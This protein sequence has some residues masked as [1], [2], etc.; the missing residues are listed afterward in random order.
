[1]ISDVR[2]VSHPDAVR[3]FDTEELREHF[4]VEGLFEPG[5]V[6]LT[7]S[8]VE[9]FVIGG[10]TPT[11]QPLT[12]E[13]DKATIGSPNFLD[14][15]ELG[16]FNIGGPGKV[17][18]DGVSYVLGHRDA[19]YVAQGTKSVVF[20]S[21]DAANPARFYLLSTPAHARYET[22]VV[23]IAE[24]KAMVLGDQATANRRT[25]YQMIH[26]DV[27]KS[28]QLV[29]GMTKLDDGNIWNTMPCHVHDRRSEVYLYFDVAADARVIHLMGEPDQ[30]RHL[31]VADG[32]AVISPPWSIHSGVGTRAYTFIWGMGGDNI[33]YTD[34]DMVAMDQLK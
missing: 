2:H 12:L 1:M 15:R 31:V 7:Y 9:R 17:E 6:Q 28:C 13:S 29:M 30:T 3:Y 4:L 8:H 26:P 11:D 14:R 16:V 25:I 24:A 5:T 32:Q 33:D 27:V 10:A 23:K 19:L 20:S 21:D 18:A 34:M 22:K